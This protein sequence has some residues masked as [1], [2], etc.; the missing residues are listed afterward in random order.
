MRLYL[1]RHGQTELNEKRCYYGCTD[2]SLNETG[3]RQAEKLGSY[4]SDM[5]WDS[6]VSS[7]LARAIDTAKYLCGRNCDKIVTDSRL[8]EQNFGIF[9]KMTA[10]EIMKRY[11]KEW[12]DWNR[13]FSDYRI[14]GGESFRDVRERIDNYVDNE[15][16]RY[17]G[18]VLLTAHKGTL[19][20][21]IAS[22]LQMPLEG[23]WN[24]VFDQGCYNVVDIEDGYAIVRGLNVPI[25]TNGDK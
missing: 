12:D 13:N 11:P 6:V 20:H 8:A 15:L 17:Q 18:T 22:L 2:V 25:I 21:M 14:S 24:F 1:I 4:F 23:Y 3:I 19:G 7:P 5:K 10:A 16:K 9:E